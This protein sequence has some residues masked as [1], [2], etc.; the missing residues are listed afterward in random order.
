MPWSSA[1]WRA[2]GARSAR[3]VSPQ[4]ILRSPT[5]R[6]SRRWRSGSASAKVTS[7]SSAS[8]SRRSRCPSAPSAHREA[9]CCA[10]RSAWP[11]CWASGT[12]RSRVRS[13][14]CALAR[15]RR[16][17][18]SARPRFS[19]ASGSRRSSPSAHRL[20]GHGQEAD[21]AALDERRKATGDA[22][23]EALQGPLS[24]ERAA[25][26]EETLAICER[27]LRRRAAHGW[28]ASWQSAARTALRSS[29]TSPVE[30]DGRVAV[31]RR[32]ALGDD[33]EAGAAVERDA[34]QPGDRVD[35]ERRADAEDQLRAL[36]K[37]RRL[38]HGLL[39]Q[40]L[41][42]EDDVGLHLAAAAPAE[43]DLLCRRRALP[44]RRSPTLSEH[45]VQLE[46]SIDPWTSITR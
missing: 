23:N 25:E 5:P 14:C 44:P 22:A 30:P 38:G 42:E 16:P 17:A 32:R 35:L 10:R 28:E 46:V 19:Y 15:T 36:A 40:E 24:A 8:G 6:P 31:V 7:W 2:S 1:A 41:A 37:R 27:V 18:A 34:G 26:V 33:R 3:G 4:R 12:R 11:P 9:R 20:T 39:G 43:G 29:T 45:D 21:L 13:S